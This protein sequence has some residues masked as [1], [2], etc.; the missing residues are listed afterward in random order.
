MKNRSPLDH[1]V[2]DRYRA[3]SWGTRLFLWARWHWTPYGEMAS[4]LPV[5]GRILDGGCGHGL[6]AL[7][8]AL[9]S[10][11]RRVLGLDH[12]KERIRAALGAGAGLRNLSFRTGDYEVLPG[13]PYEG[14]ALVDVLHYLPL[15]RQEAVLR[16][17]FRGLR[18]GGL[19]IFREVDRS[20]GFSSYFNRLHERFMTG[21]GFTRAEGLYFREPSGWTSIAQ[22][23]GFRVS[24]RPLSRFPFADILFECRKP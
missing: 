13:G 6:L 1:E 17:A 9:G 14:I 11:R 24:S 19:L 22:E 12:A 15:A 8:L 21:L 5:K 3:L 16:R 23:A 4:R 10:S 7:A 20:P 18:R 2:L